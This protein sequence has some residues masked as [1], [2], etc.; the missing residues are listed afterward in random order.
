M[1][2]S[3]EHPTSAWPLGASI[4]VG[5]LIVV[6]ALGISAGVI[7]PGLLLDAIALWPGLVPAFLAAIVTTIRR[8]WRRRSGAIS[9]LLVIT[10]IV[11]TAAAHIGGWAALP[12]SAGELIG[13]APE[14]GLATMRVRVDGRLLVGATESTYL[15]E[16]RYLRLGGQVGIPEAVETTTVAALEVVVRDRGTTPWFRYAGWRLGLDP[17]TEWN[18]HLD[19]EIAGDVSELVIGSLTLVG[20]GSLTLGVATGPTP[21][22]VMGDFIL[23]LPSGVPAMATGNF[24]APSS[25]NGDS[26]AT[27]G[28]GWII[29]VA[30]GATVRINQP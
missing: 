28:E 12:S 5:I 25:W 21:V 23:D 11:L 1:T 4:M 7:A 3:W 14:L 20:A 6:A 16:V 22:T 13:P 8:R 10:W 19:G 24:I 17:E 2:S 29:S 9:P 15:Y 26:S 27:A 18:L 30:E